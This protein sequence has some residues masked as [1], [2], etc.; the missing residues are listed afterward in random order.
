MC[1]RWPGDSETSSK[2]SAVMTGTSC[3]LP[4]RAATA[5]GCALAGSTGQRRRAS[6]TASA[7]PGSAASQAPA[8]SVPSGSSRSTVAMSASS[9]TASATTCGEALLGVE[10]RGEQLARAGDD[11]RLDARGALAGER[12]VRRALGALEA[13]ARVRGGDREEAPADD[14]EHLDDVL[15]GEQALVDRAERDREHDGERRDRRS[16]RG[17]PTPHG[18]EQRAEHEQRDQDGVGPDQHVDDREHD[19][20]RRPGRGGRGRVH[21]IRQIPHWSG[22]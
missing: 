22:C 19:D 14:D 16:S 3:G 11:V 1:S 17:R 4:V 21:A 18:G 20:E 7:M 5:T 8:R 9:G 13:L 12:G 2:C 6:R 10:R 15:G